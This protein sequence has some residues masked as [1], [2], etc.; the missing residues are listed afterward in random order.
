MEDIIN[1]VGIDTFVALAVYVGTIIRAGKGEKVDVLHGLI[2]SF[3]PFFV[4]MC[5]IYIVEY[6]L[7]WFGIV[8]PA[9]PLGALGGLFGYL[10]NS[11]LIGLSKDGKQIEEGGA[12]AS[13]VT[14]IKSVLT[15]KKQP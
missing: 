13:V 8:P 2:S 6:A 1:V 15:L 4:V 5:I 7:S 12:A 9:K 3:A 10:S 14:F 11:W